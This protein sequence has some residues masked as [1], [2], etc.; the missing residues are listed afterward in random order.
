M[1][2][3]RPQLTHVAEM[4]GA[5]KKQLGELSAVAAQG[6]ASAPRE[7]L[8]AGIKLDVKKLRDGL[9]AIGG[10]H[11][12]TKM[13]DAVAAH[14]R[15]DFLSQHLLSEEVI[16][17][18]WDH[19][20]HGPWRDVPAV[21][22]EVYAIGGVLRAEVE[23]RNCDSAA[24]IQTLDMVLMMAG[25]RILN[26][27]VTELVDTIQAQIARTQPPT[28]PKSPAR[29][30]SAAPMLKKMKTTHLAVEVNETAGLMKIESKTAVQRV[31]EPSLQ[32]FQQYMG[33][34]QPV[35]VEG[36]MTY[37]PAMG[38]AENGSRSWANL[39]YL[40]KVAGLRTVPIELGASY[41]SEDWS[42]KLMTFQ[43]FVTNYIENAEGAT[44]M[45]GTGYLAQ[46]QLFDQIPELRK[47][48]CIPDYCS[49]E[50]WDMKSDGLES[51]G[52]MPEGEVSIN[53]WFGPA[54]TKS[55]LHQDPY[56]NLLSQVVGSKFVRLY[57]PCEKKR[58]YCHDGMMQNTSRVDVE[59][60]DLDMFPEFEGVPF[61]DCILQPGEMLYIPPRWFHF[62][63]SLSVSFSVSFW[64]R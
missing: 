50:D 49:L 56:H 12:A 45:S 9:V 55:Q 2:S 32:E 37:W 4:S 10:P 25:P 39:E 61:V 14:A 20:H 8:L 15:C 34:R 19:L 28:A 40:K 26:I 35:I 36:A 43:L 53:A 21:W 51:V 11:C 64:W 17:Y 58:L 30:A 24:A 31:R 27:N 46:H 18:A 6:G 23:F 63:K 54:G 13:D 3:S 16:E 41:M 57:A 59:S 47:D 22:R 29:E 44:P 42:Q 33:G 52:L 5:S 1:S 7:N 48:I 60:P 38:N 62:V